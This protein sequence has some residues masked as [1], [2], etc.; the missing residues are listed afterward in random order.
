VIDL[1]SLSEEDRAALRSEWAAEMG[2]KGGIATAQA[3][4][5]EQRSDR[6]RKAATAR[7]GK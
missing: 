3:M 7:W 6:A 2:A 4:T 5:V 1:K